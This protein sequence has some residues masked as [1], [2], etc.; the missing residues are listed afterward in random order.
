[1]NDVLVGRLPVKKMLIAPLKT[2]VADIYNQDILS[3][4]ADMDDE[5]VAGIMEKYDL[6]VVPVVDELGRLLGRIT[7]DDIV[8]IIREEAGRDFQLASGISEN[9][10]SSAGIFTLSRARLPWL[11]IGLLGGI[12]GS[13]VIEM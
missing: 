10:D 1:D 9:V 3:V 7:I 6:V 12:M 11:L 4:Q 13:R 2:K 5:E 8:D